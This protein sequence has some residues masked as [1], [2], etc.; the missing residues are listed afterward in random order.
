MLVVLVF[1]SSVLLPP[2]SKL[3][4]TYGWMIVCIL[5]LLRIKA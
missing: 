3:L 1:V 5:L 2:F 4:V